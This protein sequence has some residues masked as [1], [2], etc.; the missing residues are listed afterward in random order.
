MTNR[1]EGRVGRIGHDLAR[2]TDPRKKAA[3]LNNLKE[4][5]EEKWQKFQSSKSKFCRQYRD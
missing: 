3:L 5:F 4:S 2:T 1:I